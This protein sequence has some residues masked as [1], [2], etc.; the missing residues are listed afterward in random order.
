MSRQEDIKN[1]PALIGAMQAAYRAK[2]ID[3]FV[4]FEKLNRQG[5]PVFNAWDNLTPLLVL[6]LAS[7]AVLLSLG[8]IAGIGCMFITIL[9]YLM[10]I[11][12]WVAHRLHG[13]LVQI[14]LLDSR[15]FQA[16]WK[17]GGFALVL[18]DTK[19]ACMAPDGDW[20]KFV[21]R[22]LQPTIQEETNVGFGL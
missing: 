22:H 5:S 14:A 8:V 15:R 17:F 16:C 1:D 21:R 6:M 12:F 18:V 2:R 13:R 4:S 3:L 9:A 19:E 20:R 7:L 10:L 11:R